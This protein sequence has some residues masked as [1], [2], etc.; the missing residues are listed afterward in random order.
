V[1]LEPA[2]RAALLASV[3]VPAGAVV[4]ACH[5]TALHSASGGTHGYT[6]SLASLVGSTVELGVVG[7]VL[8]ECAVEPSGDDGGGGGGGDGGGGGG[9]GA[10]LACVG[11]G[12]P[13]G[14]AAVQARMM[15]LRGG[16][17]RSDFALL[18]ELEGGGP[19]AARRF[20]HGLGTN[21]HPH[22]TLWT[23]PGVKA[24]DSNRTMRQ[25][26]I[27]GGGGGGGGVRAAA[28]RAPLPATL[29]GV[30]GFSCEAGGEVVDLAT[31]AAWE[32]WLASNFGE[33]A[34]W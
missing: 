13:G 19:G 9:G 33:A 31:Q 32:G 25:G 23:A 20:R 5:V 28:L 21:E 7:P 17:A 3:A 24:A 22:V 10:R 34:G 6:R 12:W 2:S 8:E 11:V 29:R 1:F 16:S 4:R 27:G 26:A 14:A 18:Q 15:G 30:V